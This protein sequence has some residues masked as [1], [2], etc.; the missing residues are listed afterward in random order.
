MSDGDMTGSRI[1]C[2]GRNYAAHIRELGHP[3]D[4]DCVVFMKPAS[5]LVD[6][7]RPLHLPT[8]LG[9]VHHEA[10][11]VVRIGRAGRDIDEQAAREHVDA[12]ALGLDLTLRDEQSRLRAD[13]KPWELAKAF[14]GAAPIG[15]FRAVTDADDLADLRFTCHVNDALRQDGH[16]AL[17]L[18]PV[19]R[20]IAILS[21]TWTLQPGDL[22]YTGTPA[23][24]GPLNYGD[25][26]RL[27]GAGCTP[28]AWSVTDDG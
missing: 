20:I 2:I 1:F 16:T 8:G 14:D 19:T 22:I 11:L 21:A 25:T 18:F 26:V 17:M 28:A 4:G 3:E 13:G 9:A 27:T 10:E 12:I 24:V 5:C 15:A 6:A 7:G 23:G